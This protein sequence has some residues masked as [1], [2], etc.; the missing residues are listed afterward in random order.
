MSN[1]LLAAQQMAFH[2][3]NTR[4]SANPLAEEEV[5][6]NFSLNGKLCL[7]CSPGGAPSGSMARGG[8]SLCVFNFNRVGFVSSAD[9]YP[10]PPRSGSPAQHT[11]GATPCLLQLA[12]AS[13]ALSYKRSSLPLPL[14]LPASSQQAPL[15]F[16]YQFTSLPLLLYK[17]QKDKS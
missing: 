13:P 10:E 17:N 2:F 8:T 7:Q 12:T 6:P 5:P 14:R 15:I 4:G 16:A 9:R 11:T 3:M 1:S